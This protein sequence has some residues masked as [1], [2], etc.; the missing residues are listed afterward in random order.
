MVL[1]L[2][3]IG[4][5]CFT[6]Q[7]SFGDSSVPSPSKELQRAL[8]LSD[9]YNWREAAPSFAAAEAFHVRA[10]DRRNALLAKL[11]GIRATI[12]TR[13]LPLTSIALEKQLETEPLL[14]HDQPLR[15]FCLAIKGDIDREVDARIA[16]RDWDQVKKIATAIGDAH[17]QNRALAEIGIS[18]FFEGDLQTARQNVGTAVQVAGQIHDF[19]AQA[20]FTSVLGLALVKADMAEQALPY[21]DQALQIAST[22]PDSGY[23][24]FIYQSR[25]EALIS[26][27]RYDEAQKLG[28]ELLA[29]HQLLHSPG[30]IAEALFLCAQIAAA[31]G[32]T[33]LAIKDLEKSIHIC[34]SIGLRETA[35]EPEAMLAAIY[36]Q[37]GDLQKAARYAT[38]AV[39]SAQVSGD[40]WGI[41]ERLRTLAEIQIAN[42]QYL[43][44]DRTFDKAAAFIDAGLTNSST[45]M[46]KTAYVKASSDLYS[47]HFALVVSKL[48]N[49][50]KAFSIVEQVRGRVTAD[51]LLAG[52]VH[53]PK[54]KAAEA[55][56]SRLQLNL[57][58][59]HTVA[60]VNRV[61]AQVIAAQQAR[62]I[63]PGVNI[64]KRNAQ[65]T[66]SLNLVRQ[67]LDSSTLV[68]EY[69]VTDPQSYCLVISRESFEVVPLASKSEI[70]RLTEAYLKAVQ[71]KSPAH[72][73]GSALYAALL[74]PIPGVERMEKLVIVR[75]G[76]LHQIPFDALEDEAGRVVA[77]THIVA[78]LPSV[79]SLYLL[80]LGSGKRPL[81]PLLA[82]GGVP[83]AQSSIRPVSFT[84]DRTE[85][86]QELLYSRKEILA[87]NA[88]VAGHNNLLLGSSA[89]ESAFKT[90]AKEHYGIIHLAVH[91]IAD[92]RDAE[93]SALVLL[94]DQKAGEDGLLHAAEI[95]MMRLD[96]N[97]VVL[98][99]CDTAV[100]PIQGEEGI[101][102]LSKAFLLAGAKGVIST[103]WSV[104]DAS[105]LFLMQHFYSALAAGDPPEV[106]LTMAKRALL[107]KFGPEAVPFYWAG[108][109]FEG[110]LTSTEVKR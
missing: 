20:R 2:I 105:S 89:T 35:A 79:T 11:G 72:A 40:R 106:A 88:A 78:H 82:V 60:D 15:L 90:A 68:L 92:Q 4:V 16:R 23:P 5:V 25:L 63:N 83:Y 56:I 39:T 41:P 29:R 59:A 64:L 7:L 94:P 27:H 81:R 69:V 57:M 87:A 8:Y 22:I 98:S 53:S 109:T 21:F 34:R 54:A 3:A 18:A 62:W 9:L 85:S 95:A 30:P 103:L 99:A 17:W 13:N 32:Q 45:V 75:D 84:A 6:A 36:R 19:A 86:A 96:T 42:G 52:S 70:D 24:S 76:R 1:P 61:R 91:G 28:D 74:R 48:H 66:V 33:V 49:P 67:R 104:D 107:K 31:R 55:S 26:L 108:F 43:D 110:A 73:E 12:E 47:E 65:E 93:Q 44:A 100:G 38:D 80:G 58:T 97:L 46:E 10:G 37:Q 101:A 71:N 50:A 51:L 14:Q 102:T 77:A